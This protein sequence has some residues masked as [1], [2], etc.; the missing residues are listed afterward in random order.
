[1]NDR[2]QGTQFEHKCWNTYL[3]GDHIL[4]HVF[5][6]KKKYIKNYLAKRYAQFWLHQVKVYGH[7]SYH[8]NMLSLIESIGWRL[9][10]RKML[11]CGIGTGYPFAMEFACQGWHVYGVD[12][13]PLLIKECYQNARKAGLDIHSHVGDVESLPYKDSVFDLTY[14]LQS[15]W[16]F[17]DLKRA[18]IEMIRVTKPG[19][20]II[21]DIMNLLSSIILRQQLATWWHCLLALPKMLA[22]WMLRSTPVR[23]LMWEINPTVPARLHR[24]LRHQNVSYITSVPD[25]VQDIE[26]LPPV[27]WFHHRL[28]Y[29]CQ[30]RQ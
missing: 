7:T 29:I 19:G 3:R 14:C 17:E 6:L 2:G 16:Y 10:G 21:F 22:K 24:I 11:E 1:M 26:H 30:K 28:V 25:N 27:N 23:M 12:I 13:A 15:T 8:Q 18:I 5:K 9:N 4:W 20:Y